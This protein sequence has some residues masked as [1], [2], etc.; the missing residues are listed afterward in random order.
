MK[1]ISILLFVLVFCASCELVPKYRIKNIDTGNIVT[2]EN[3]K[4][5]LSPDFRVGDTVILDGAKV[6]ILEDFNKK[7][8]KQVK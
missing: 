7:E 6:V 1:K 2:V 3:N 5:E 4:R 8:S